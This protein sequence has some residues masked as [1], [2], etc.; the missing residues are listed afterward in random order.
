MT[1]RTGRTIC[2]F[3][4]T[5]LVLL[6]NSVGQKSPISDL[7]EWT[8]RTGVVLLG[9]EMADAGLWARSGSI[10]TAYPSFHRILGFSKELELVSWLL[11]GFLIVQIGVDVPISHPLK[12]SCFWKRTV[13]QTSSLIFML[14]G[15][16]TRFFYRMGCPGFFSR[17]EREKVTFRFYRLIIYWS[18]FLFSF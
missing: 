8:I 15:V 1:R 2:F 4:K 12:P 18:R 3:R 5:N 14:T 13:R 11:F 10:T 6:S 9:Y 16:S 7:M 17:N